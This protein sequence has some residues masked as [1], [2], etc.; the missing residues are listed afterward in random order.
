[1]HAGTQQTKEFATTGHCMARC[2]VMGMGWPPRKGKPRPE[3][4]HNRSC[5]DNKSH[6]TAIVPTDN[7]RSPLPGSGNEIPSGVVTGELLYA[8]GVKPSCPSVHSWRRRGRWMKQSEI[9]VAVHLQIQPLDECPSTWTICPRSRKGSRLRTADDAREIAAGS[10]HAARGSCHQR[11]TDVS[12]ARSQTKRRR[13][14]TLLCP[15]FDHSYSEEPMQ[16]GKQ[17]DRMLLVFRISPM[18]PGKQIKLVE[19][20]TTQLDRQLCN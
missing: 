16:R 13:K 2:C 7:I 15:A 6:P 20:T 4:S 14:E 11:E 5:Q 10:G 8:A 18:M 12:I 1:M 19:P 17:K 9:P 3:R